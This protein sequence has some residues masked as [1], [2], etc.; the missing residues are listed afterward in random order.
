MRVHNY[1]C[2]W[3]IGFSEDTLRSHNSYLMCGRMRFLVLREKS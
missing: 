2:K 1:L 3:G